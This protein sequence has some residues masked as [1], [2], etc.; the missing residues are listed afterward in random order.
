MIHRLPVTRVL[1]GSLL[2]PAVFGALVL[3]S[4]SDRVEQSGRV[5]AAVV[6]L[7]KPVTT[8]KGKNEQ[9]IYAGRLLAAGLTSPARE[10][11]SNLGWEL[12]D[13]ESAEAGLADGDYYAVITIPEDF[14]RSISSVQGDRPR[15]AEIS[16][17]SNDAST[18]LAAEASRQVAQVAAARLGDRVTTTFL[19]GLFDRSGRLRVQLG[20]ASGAAGQVAD[21]AGR[22]ADGAG[23]LSDG[24]GRLAGGLDQ[25]SGGADRLASGATRLAGG[26]GRLDAGAHR[27][28]DG[29]GRLERRTDPLP[30]QTDRLA[31]GAGR[32]AEGAGAYAQLLTAWK[33][34]CADPL[35]VGAQPRLCAITVQAVGPT[36]DRA[37]RLEE[38]SDDLATGVRRL[39]DATPA[40]TGAI[41]RTAA[42]GDALAGGARRLADGADRLASGARRLAGGA[43]EAGAGAQQLAGGSQQLASGSGRLSNGSGRLADGLAS[44]ADRIPEPAKDAA[45]VVADPVATTSSRLNPTADGA[46]ALAPLVLAL[47]LWL[48]AF[49]TYLVRRALPAASSR[50]ARA[51]WRS[52]LAGW[53]PALLVGAVQAVLLVVTAL[54]FGASFTAP[55]GVAAMALLAVA[56]FAAV[57]QAFV[58]A[59]GRRRGWVALIA[60]TALQVVA[61]GGLVPIET[62]P[63]AL[64]SLNALLPVARA[65]DVF[66]HLTIGGQVGSPLVSALV[67]GGWGLAA[68]AVT[69][70]AARRRQ[71]LSVADL[72]RS[73]E[74]PGVTA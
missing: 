12:T 71:R 49:V 60:F 58:V 16:V 44:G 63:A 62:A 24:A 28:A 11:D 31:D 65:A 22:L 4:S 9:I 69:T 59:L 61:L 15:S 3:W 23:R 55:V 38:G 57:T 54:L 68:L 74:G 51:G 29:L 64:Q 13:A 20:K 66:A 10:S 18:P 47:G 53:L 5:P 73:L 17:E 19:D 30:G 32:V 34:A 48:G 72:R 39:A 70:L 40:L 36:G 42:G 45:D 46:T 67:V 43:A 1:L 27:L 8:G 14:S 33:D 41:D 37:R 50:A 35:V 2:L 25:L 6:N 21:G 52:A 7:D 56:G 26:A